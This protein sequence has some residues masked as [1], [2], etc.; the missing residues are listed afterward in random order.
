MFHFSSLQERPAAAFHQ[1]DAAGEAQSFI[2]EPVRG[3]SDRNPSE[4]LCETVD[5]Q[6]SDSQGPSPQRKSLYDLSH[7]GDNE[8]IVREEKRI[9]INWSR[10]NSPA[11]TPTQTLKATTAPVPITTAA[12]STEKPPAKEEESKVSL[13][14]MAPCPLEISQG[15]RKKTSLLPSPIKTSQMKSAENADAPKE[16]QKPPSKALL[17]KIAMKETEP[18]QK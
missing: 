3:E 4:K 17:Q 2:T 9:S 7:L 13:A 11:P 10:D 18:R 15:A 16:E 12:V 1:V 14:D 8:L 5:E 6:S